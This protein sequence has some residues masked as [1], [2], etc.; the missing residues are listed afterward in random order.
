MEARSEPTTA[1]ERI[2]LSA[3]RANTSAPT[4][5]IRFVTTLCVVCKRPECSCVAPRVEQ[6]MCGGWI[7]AFAGERHILRAV[8]AHQATDRHRAWR[9]R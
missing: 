5:P 7:S 9:T 6:C 3:I 2:D 8:R 4:V 1:D